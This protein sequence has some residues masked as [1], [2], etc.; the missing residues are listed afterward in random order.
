[1]NN[2][3]NDQ[4]LYTVSEIGQNLISAV[5]E[6][7]E[8]IILESMQALS[9]AIDVDRM[10]IW[11]NYFKDYKILAK[12][13][14]QWYRN[15]G[16]E[17]LNP[18]SYKQF[19]VPD[20]DYDNVPGWKEYCLK[21]IIVNCAVKDLGTEEQVSLEAQGI[22]SILIIPIHINSQFWGFVGFANCHSEQTYSSEQVE[23]LQSNTN[24]M[25]ASIIHNRVMQ[26]LID[27][28]Q[29]LVNRDKL[30]NA[31]NS[32][33][34]LL[35][36]KNDSDFDTSINLSLEIAAKAVGVDR[37]YLWKNTIIDDE[38]YCSKLAEWANL[39]VF[40]AP[41]PKLFPQ[42][43]SYNKIYPGWEQ[44]YDT[45]RTLNNE[46]VDMDQVF[47]SFPV[48]KKVKAM[49]VVPIYIENN[50]WGFVG[51]DETKSVRHFSKE[52]KDILTVGGT[53][54]ASA[55]DRQ[56]T[57]HDLLEA[58]EKAILSAQAKSDFLSRMSHEIRTPMNAI[59]GMT[60]LARKNSDLDKIQ[61]YLGKV[62]S[63]SQQLLSLIND[64]LDMSKIDANKLEIV[65]SEFDFDRMMEH[66]F[67]VIQVK[68]DEKQL[69]FQYIFD[70][71]FEHNMVSD[72]LRISQV[73][74]NLLS[75]AVKFTPNYGTITL[76]V[77]EQAISDNKSLL[78]IE[79][80]DTGVG[81]SLDRQKNLFQSF[82]Q[83]DGSI[84]RQYGGT[85]LGLAIC[86]KIIE[87]MGGKIWLE[88]EEGK[89]AK[90][91][92]EI[93]IGW[94]NKRELIAADAVLSSDVKI[95]IVDDSEIACENFSHILS[96]AGLSHDIVNSGEEALEL[97]KANLSKGIQYDICFIDYSMPGLNGAETASE[98]QRLTGSAAQVIMISSYNWDEIRNEAADHGVNKFLA[99]PIMPST[100]FDTVV[101]MVGSGIVKGKS[102]N[103]ELAPDDWQHKFVLLA[104]DIEIN[105]EIVLSI[106]EDSKLN[107]DIATNGKE[108]YEIFQQNMDKYDLILMDIQMPLMDGISATKNI[109]ALSAPK[110]Q[111]I[112]II[113][114]T[115]NAFKEDEQAC[116]A[117]GMNGHIAKPIEVDKLFSTLENYL[118]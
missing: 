41:N 106:L 34:I 97:V 55:I 54:I 92:F 72:E 73:L 67:N 56:A 49:M 105:R 11:E 81:I 96:D 71:L 103:N 5:P 104:E 61:N 24:A 79:V 114:M 48:M 95:L 75:N 94:G 14:Y 29:V 85:G 45:T 82:E 12:Q 4:L 39:E 17:A 65:E 28:K 37:S 15:L 30:L 69:D 13:I 57:A 84:T 47:A 62:N 66:V 76:I 88:S 68:M 91:I 25:I 98:I 78:H 63:S 19:A 70:H 112:P 8:Q 6:N 58:K 111:E 2:S 22:L 118:N 74:T 50:F 108:A 87:L 26:D 53:L 52:E 101:Q 83:A 36:S 116:M 38:I 64:I 46:T 102:D 113:A 27:T 10:Y 16:D 117:A 99:K 1:M 107:I 115:A 3:N 32:I 40:E 100:F 77:K 31:V 20:L 86:K 90:F 35:L 59:I 42:N 7:F 18:D 109:R 9:L 51:F 43:L 89:G 44:F 60:N 80:N 21:S 110:A 93:E 23:I 33:A